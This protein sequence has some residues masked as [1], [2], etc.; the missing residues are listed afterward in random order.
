M[1]RG[2]V[3]SFKVR[4]IK[5]TGLFQS[6]RFWTLLLD[7]VISLTL[8]FVGKYGVVAAEDVNFLIIT[9]QPVFVAL[10]GAYTVDDM[11]AARTE[12]ARIAAGKS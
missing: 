11:G 4:E 12:Q 10:I 3:F 9:L 7:V 2:P 8:Y 6:R 1:F 5:M